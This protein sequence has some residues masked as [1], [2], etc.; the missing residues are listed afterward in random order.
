L[1]LLRSPAPDPQARPLP[2]LILSDTWKVVR[3]CFEDDDLDT[4]VRFRVA[5]PAPKDRKRFPTM[6]ILKWEY[7]AKRDG[8][9]RDKDIER[10]AAFEDEL[11]RAVEETALGYPVACLTGNGRRTWRYYVDD[12]KPFLAALKPV[13]AAHEAAFLF[14]QVADPAWGGLT[15]LLPLLE[16]EEE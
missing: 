6:L 9:P 16:C 13:L 15:E 10:M 11:E 2:K 1:V 7:A 3:M 14:K 8:M 12:P 4:V 5:L